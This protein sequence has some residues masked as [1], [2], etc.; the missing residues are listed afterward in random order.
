MF[1]YDMGK[2]LEIGITNTKGSQI[3]KISEVEAFKG[4]GLEY[5]R[6]YIN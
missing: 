4:K 2:V 3:Q 1:L 6:R 5:S